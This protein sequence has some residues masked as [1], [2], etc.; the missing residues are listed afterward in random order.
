MLCL[1]THQTI[2]VRSTQDQQCL[3]RRQLKQ[4]SQQD[5]GTS[6]VFNDISAD[7]QV[8]IDAQ[9]RC[10]KI[11]FIQVIRQPAMVRIQSCAMFDRICLINTH[12]R[13]CTVE[14]LIQLGSH[15]APHVQYSTALSPFGQ[16]ASQTIDLMLVQG[17]RRDAPFG[18]VF[19]LAVR[20]PY[21][22]IDLIIGRQA[23]GV[24]VRQSFLHD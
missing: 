4:M 8:D 24:V 3:R 23:E 5:F 6:E 21:G 14:V 2:T 12:Q 11:R 20:R 15:A 16:A 7:H 1:S 9:I 13:E 18:P 17:A 22:S 10:A 19:R